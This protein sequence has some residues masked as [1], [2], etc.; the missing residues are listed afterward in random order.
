MPGNLPP[1]GGLESFGIENPLY[2]LCVSVIRVCVCVF[3]GHLIE[4]GSLLSLVG[5]GDGTQKLSLGN[6]NL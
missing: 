1:V 6:K 2:S 3:R 5:P 4:V